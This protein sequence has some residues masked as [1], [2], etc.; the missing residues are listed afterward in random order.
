MNFPS[1]S[2]SIPAETAS[3]KLLAIELLAVLCLGLLPPIAAA[4]EAH[5]RRDYSEN[6]TNSDL[7]FWLIGDLSILAPLLYIMW[8][9]S[10]GWAEFGIGRPKYVAD[11]A[12]SVFILVTASDVRRLDI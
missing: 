12:L 6:F 9:S 11:I 5:F 2:A 8:R 10:G 4:L 1:L 3:K 7:L